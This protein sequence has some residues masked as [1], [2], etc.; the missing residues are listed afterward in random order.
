MQ[1]P[2]LLFFTTFFLLLSSS[3][4]GQ[5]SFYF[6]DTLHLLEVSEAQNSRLYDIEVEFDEK[7]S[8]Q[9]SQQ[10]LG[11]KLEKMKLERDRKLEEVLSTRQLK[12]LNEKRFIASKSGSA[13]TVKFLSDYGAFVEKTGDVE[14]FTINE[15]LPRAAAKKLEEIASKH[16][17]MKVDGFMF[18]ADPLDP[19]RSEIERLRE[20]WVDHKMFSPYTGPK[21][22][23]GFHPDFCVTWTKNEATFYALICLGCSELKFIAPRKKVTFDFERMALNLFGQFAAMSFRERKKEMKAYKAPGRP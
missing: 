1:H 10:K 3:V 6:G 19:K 23:G 7:Y 21:F 14:T 8:D 20:K 22:C 5:V 15:G 9:F 17:T 12:V 18:Y 16:K 13:N 2:S 11:F 4:M